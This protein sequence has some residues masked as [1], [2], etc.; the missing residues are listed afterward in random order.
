MPFTELVIPSLVQ[1]KEARDAFLDTLLP[2]LT[3][4]TAQT[5]GFVR[6]VSGHKTTENNVNVPESNFFPVLGIGEYF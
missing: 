4:I 1:S 2:T 5:R 3:S 6:S